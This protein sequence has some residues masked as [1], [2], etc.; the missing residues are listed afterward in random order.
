[1]RLQMKEVKRNGSNEEKYR[2]GINAKR[3]GSEEETQ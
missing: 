2:R 3:K 1:M